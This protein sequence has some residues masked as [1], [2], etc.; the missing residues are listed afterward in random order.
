MTEGARIATERAIRQIRAVSSP[1]RLELLETL[2][3]GGVLS[4]AELARRVPA[5]RGGI[6]GT[7]ADLAEAG[8]VKLEDGI[9]RSATWVATESPILWSDI[10]EDDA[11]VRAAMAS[12]EQ[13]ARQRRFA[14]IKTFE[15]EWQDA[16]WPDEWADAAVSRDYIERL[17][18]AELTEL[19]TE[20]HAAV[21]RARTKA[22]ARRDQDPAGEE[23]VFLTVMAF[24]R[25]SPR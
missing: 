14:Y 17:T 24:P 7:L 9:G 23:P 25:Q 10:D 12:M 18:P 15:Q 5:A 8:W 19:D 21:T 2:R 20:I 11:P 6:Q 4:T 16:K 22:Q 13:A 1:I 3:L